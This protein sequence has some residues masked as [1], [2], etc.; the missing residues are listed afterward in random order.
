M[1]R[2]QKFPLTEQE[3]RALAHL[4][5][6]QPH[7]VKTNKLRDELKKDQAD[8][9]L[10]CKA[11]DSQ[12]KE[13]EKLRARNNEL[14]KALNNPLNTLYIHPHKLFPSNQHTIY[15]LIPNEY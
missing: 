5:F 14:E 4:L 10:Y 1:A 2:R 12:Q 7:V 15:C 11:F 3:E 13:L 9:V 8:I 6:L